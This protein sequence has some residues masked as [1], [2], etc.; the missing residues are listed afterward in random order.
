MKHVLTI[1]TCLVLSNSFLVAQQDSYDADLAAKVG[2]DEYG[3]KRYVMAFL[4]AGDSVAKYTPDERAEIQIGHMTNINRLS[5][6][7]KLIL[8]GPFIE[9]GEMRGIFIF[10]V[11]TKAEAE[12]LTN[13]DPAVKAGVLKMNLVEWYGSAALMFMPENQKKVQKKSF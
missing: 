13:S 10:D 12:E 11:S 5:E 4:L 3:M 7:K 6:L 9:G 8:A 1:F 2:A